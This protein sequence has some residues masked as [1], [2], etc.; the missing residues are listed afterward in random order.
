MPPE[1]FSKSPE[2]PKRKYAEDIFDQ[3]PEVEVGVEIPRVSI[4]RLTAG[5]AVSLSLSVAE[6][7]GR[8]GWDVDSLKTTG[9]GD[10]VINQRT[11]EVYV[12]V[13]VQK[14]M[15]KIREH[16]TGMEGAI[17]ARPRSLKAHEYLYS[18]RTDL[19]LSKKVKV[20]DAVYLDHSLETGEFMDG[21]AGSI[22]APCMDVFDEIQVHP[23]STEKAGVFKT[24]SAL[25]SER[26]VLSAYVN[27]SGHSIDGVRETIYH[28]L[29][30]AIAK[31]LKGKVNPGEKWKQAMREDGN[32]VSKYAAKT[33]YPKQNDN[34]EIEDF[35]EAVMMYLA[36]DGAKE[37]RARVLRDFCKSRF[38]KLDEVFAELLVRQNSS[39]LDALKR[40]LLKPIG[41]L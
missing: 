41:S 26:R 19:G 1:R 10:L 31:Y 27:D 32:E 23:Q 13:E 39:R 38:Q 5:K 6:N 24:E 29:G 11:G 36:T 14:G 17:V 37:G 15:L 28:E 8:Q 18:I 12:V 7:L 2:V 30:H 9:K 16:E 21:V 34:G 25:F 20:Y 40:R 33:R 4:T 22:P 35:A 3:L